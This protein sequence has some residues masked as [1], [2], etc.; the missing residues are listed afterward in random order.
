MCVAEVVVGVSEDDVGCG[1]L[2]H[3]GC[4]GEEECEGVV[5]DGGVDGFVS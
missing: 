3:D 5:G 4:G 2:S 1:V